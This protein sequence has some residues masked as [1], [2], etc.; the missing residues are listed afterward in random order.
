MSDANNLAKLIE[1]IIKAKQELCYNR[2][3]EML[4]CDRTKGSKMR[5]VMPKTTFMNIDMSMIDPIMTQALRLPV[6]AKVRLMERLMVVL[7]QELTN[8]QAKQPLL[9]WNGLC[10]DLG[11]A[12]SAEE[13]DA[14]RS[15]A[16]ADF[17][18]SDKVNYQLPC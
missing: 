16:W 10:A 9:P 18:R 17:P 2:M 5:T 6:L 12:P 14:M 15:E 13:I 3:K 11:S 7:E 1:V 4:L 8:E